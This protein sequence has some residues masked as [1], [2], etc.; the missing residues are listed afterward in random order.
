MFL[1]SLPPSSS[2]RTLAPHCLPWDRLATGPVLGV[3]CKLILQLSKPFL[4][5]SCN[6]MEFGIF[7]VLFVWSQLQSWR[8][9]PR[10]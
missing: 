8:K 9:I 2:A 4:G 7:S 3:L 10:L 1:D 6:L 5:C